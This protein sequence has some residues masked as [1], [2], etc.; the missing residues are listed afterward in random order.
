[1]SPILAPRQLGVGTHG[2]VEASIHAARAFSDSATVSHA[3][4]G[5][6]QRI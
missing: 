3:L 2:G 6:C 4:V 1:M 5:F